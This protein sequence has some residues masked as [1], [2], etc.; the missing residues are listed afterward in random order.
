MSRAVAVLLVCATWWAVPGPAGA[1]SRLTG[2]D[3]RGTV[4]DESGAVIRGANV[5]VT[6]TE[7]NLTRRAVT[8]DSG[9]YVVAA[10]PPGTYRVTVE[11]TGFAAHTHEGLALLLGQSPDVSFTLKLAAGREDLVVAAVAPVVDPGQ[12]AVSS[13]VGQQQIEGLPI[14]KRDFLSFTVITPGVTTDRTPQQGASATSGLSFGGQRARSNNI[15]VDG[16]DNNDPVVGAVRAT[17]SQEAIREFQVLTNSYS[18]EFGK[19]S[20]G[21]VNIVTKSGTNEMHGNAFFY[22]RDD[23]LNAKDHF[24][25]EDVFGNPVDRD[26]A[27]FHQYQYGA[28]LGG[29]LKKDRTFFFLSFEQVDVGA[30]NFVNIEQTAAASLRAAGFPVDTGNVPYDFSTTEVLAKLDH[31]WSPNHN[32]VLR[33][34]F[35]DTTNENIEPFGGLVARSRGAV[36][37]RTDWAI[38]ASQIDVLSPRWVNEARVQFAREDQMI[39]S[40][41][42]SCQGEC[43]LD[44]EGGPTLEVTGVASV[45]RQRFTPQP[46]LNERIQVMD[47]VSYQGGSHFL[48]AGVDFNY[49]RTLQTALPLHFGGR[50]IFAALPA[51]PGLLPQ[52][53]SSLQALQLGLPAAYVQGY[54]TPGGSYNDS[55]VSLF[56]QDDW[57]ISPRLI[58]KVG[59]R[60]QRQF[61]YDLDYTVS[62]LGGQAYTYELPDDRNNLAPRVAIAWDPSGDARTSVHAAYGIFYENQI[63]AIPQ[64][65]NGLRGDAET[66]RTLVLRIPQSLSA[67]RAPGHR[68]TEAQ[69]TAL[70]GGSYASLVISPDPGIETPYSHQAAAGV[71]RAFGQDF[72]LSANFVYVRGKNQL[73]TIDYNPIVP[74]LGANRRPNDAGGRAGT[75]AS[76]LQY[77]SF[78]ETWYR[79]LTVSANKRF[80]ASTQLL[81]SYTLSKAE[82]SS[83]DFQSAFIVQNS[84]RGRNPADLTGLPLGFDPLSEK[85]PATHDQRHRFVFSGLHRFPW[86]L[87]ASAIIT[88]ASG[89]PFNP[90]AGADLNGD[91]DGG[92]FPADRAR[93]NPADAASSVGRNSGVMDGQFNVDVRLSK[94][95]RLGQKT[96]VDL[97]AEAFNLLDR[98]NFSEINNIFGRG[99][100]PN[101]P[102]RDAQGRVTYGLY[103][104]ALPPRQVQLALKVSF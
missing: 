102:Q 96:A 40:L 59:L 54:G 34:N 23:Q 44:G 68:L 30:N 49:I 76:I 19:S 46:R 95:F 84:G 8:D 55:D 83:T 1:Q 51:I 38:A 77:T 90:L 85:G 12:T 6:N 57:R 37:L 41:D 50:Y 88:A 79:G 52:P 86:D 9:R 81:L 62:N 103:E 14:N 24:E 73:G 47:T 35:A 100:F 80:G 28:T 22:F 69:G 11:H 89:R 36:Q 10:L 27:P 15:M 29:P 5:T 48:K 66:V 2:A 72:S 93:R 58:L 56:V 42:P 101:E 39:Q 97:I 87:T 17:F 21:V 70:A 33:G 32:F 13:V 94:R 63:I 71:D 65:A 53:V 16:V 18:A 3:V 92:A 78:G 4:T 25:K 75:S 43:D 67:W 45:G 64:I 98:T 7:T 26:K 82:D 60:Y 104:Q 74:A 99:A 91:G 20:G 61:A 31:Q